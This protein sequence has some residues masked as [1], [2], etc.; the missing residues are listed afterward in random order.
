MFDVCDVNRPT[1]CGF[2]PKATHAMTLHEDF[3][4]TERNFQMVL[5]KVNPTAIFTPN[6]PHPLFL[7]QH[8]PKPAPT[9]RLSAKELSADGMRVL[10]LLLLLQAF[11]FRRSL[12]T[13][14]PGAHRIVRSTETEPTCRA[15]WQPAM[16]LQRRGLTCRDGK[17]SDLPHS[18]PTC[19]HCHVLVMLH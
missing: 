17:A 10:F 1:R 9:P 12:E 18:G 13:D 19:L 11:G 16:T 6:S 4:C 14:A 2:Q 8:S 5:A 15:A 3:T 7:Q